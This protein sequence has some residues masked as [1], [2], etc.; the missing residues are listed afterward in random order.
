[1]ARSVRVPIQ[2]TRAEFENS[3]G[4]GREGLERCGA[5]FTSS[6]RV[7]LQWQVASGHNIS[8]HRVARAYHLRAIAFFDETL[9]RAGRD[10]QK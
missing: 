3:S 7:A 6:P 9:A 5:L 2:L 4:G 10:N 8:L 1:M